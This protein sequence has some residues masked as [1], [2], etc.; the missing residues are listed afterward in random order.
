MEQETCDIVT[1]PSP[2]S[3]S[4]A[5]LMFTLYLFIRKRASHP[6]GFP[7]PPVPKPLPIIGNVLDIAR[8][9]EVEAYQ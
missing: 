2:L 9:N 1:S 6:H 7:Y 8:K 4:H 3:I 5:A